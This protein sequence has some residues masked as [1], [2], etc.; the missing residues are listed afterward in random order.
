MPQITANANILN[1]AR[2]AIAI[3]LQ[4]KGI[5]VELKPKAGVKTPKPGGGHDFVPGLL[6]DPQQISLTK[7]G[8]DIIEDSSNDGAQYIVRNYILTGEWNMRIALGDTWEDDEAEYK[9]DTLDQTSG[10]KTSA[11]VIGYVKL[12]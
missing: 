1:A 12:P 2:K 6:R 4:F 11:D 10:F 9:V 7:V 5:S 3:M 8:G